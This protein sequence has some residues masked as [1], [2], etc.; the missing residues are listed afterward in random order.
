MPDHFMHSSSFD[1]M[2]LLAPSQVTSQTEPVHC[3]LTDKPWLIILLAQILH[4]KNI[5]PN[6]THE[7]TSDSR[8]LQ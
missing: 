2:T 5:Y 8:W 1:H 4:K 6:E 7:G 3:L